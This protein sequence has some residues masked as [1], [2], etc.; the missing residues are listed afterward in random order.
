M[1]PGAIETGTSTAVFF[2]GIAQNLRVYGLG[3]GPDPATLGIE[4]IESRI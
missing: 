2:K 4:Q 3:R 1:Q